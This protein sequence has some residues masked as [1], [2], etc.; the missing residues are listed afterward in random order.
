MLESVQDVEDEV[1]DVVHSE[2]EEVIEVVQSEVDDGVA[3]AAAES[4]QEVLLEETTAG[5]GPALAP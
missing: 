1:V 5:A 3:A 4:V 2:V